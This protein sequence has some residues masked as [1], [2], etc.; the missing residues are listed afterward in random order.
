MFTKTHNSCHWCPNECNLNT[1]SLLNKKR[2]NNQNRL[3]ASHAL[4]NK[5]ALIVSHLVGQSAI[6]NHL[7]QAGGPGDLWTSKQSSTTGATYRLPITKVRTANK[8]NSG[9]D[10]KHGSYDRYLARKVGGVLRKENMPYD[11]ADT[12]ENCFNSQC[13]DNRIP[14]D[15]NKCCYTLSY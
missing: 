6:P 9:V 4:L 1:L 15:C 14:S 3:S 11:K 13:C 2:R 7:L 8:N 12:Y 5:K 10:K